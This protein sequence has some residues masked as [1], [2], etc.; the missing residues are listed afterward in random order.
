[1]T[2]DVLDQVA[3]TASELFNV[4]RAQLTPASSPDSVPD[5]D[6]VQHLNLVLAL[7]QRFG[8]QFD[9]EDIE[10]MRSIGEIAAIVSRRR[11]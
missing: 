9:P 2:D 11:G 7:E 10:K 8:V 1:M 6:S 3:E 5:W 4:P